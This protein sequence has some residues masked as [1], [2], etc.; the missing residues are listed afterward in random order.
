MPAAPPPVDTILMSSNCFFATKSAFLAAAQTTIAVPCWSS[1]KTGIFILLLQI[2]STSKQSG[3]LISSKFIAPKVGSKAQMIS[4]SLLGSFS[5]T[6]KSK[7]SILA[8]FL[9][10][11]AF[12]SITGFEAR[13]PILPNPKTAEPLLT[14]ATKLAR[15]VYLLTSSGFLSMAIEASATPGE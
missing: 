2:F 11:T 12:P 7:Q 9:N 15:E 3:A 13:A 4:A 14:T 1:W 5:F 6:S 8:N 10:R